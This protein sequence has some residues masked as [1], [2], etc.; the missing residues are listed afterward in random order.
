[1]KLWT[2]Q[3]GLDG[4]HIHLGTYATIEE[5]AAARRTGEEKY[6]SEWSLNNSRKE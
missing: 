3:I 4:K 6:F 5:A 1:M 2:A